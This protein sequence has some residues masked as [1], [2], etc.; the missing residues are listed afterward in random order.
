M[1]VEHLG[2]KKFTEQNLP[3]VSDSD[4]ERLG[5]YILREG[6]VIFSRVGSVERCS[7]VSNEYDRMVMCV[8]SI[9]LCYSENLRLR[10]A[11]LRNI[12]KS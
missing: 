6:D 11:L 9:A 2:K 5:K 12:K 7:Y 1:T 8:K 3:C 10:M 4:K